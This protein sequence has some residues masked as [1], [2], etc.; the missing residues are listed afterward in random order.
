M[1]TYPQFR[2]RG[3]GGRLPDVAEMRER[4]AG[5]SG[6]SIIASDANTGA[7]RLYE[8]KGYRRKAE[9]P[10]IKEDWQNPGENRVLLARDL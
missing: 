9:R 10:M 4:E 3:I 5:L 7:I 6:L 8:R 1:G 2:G